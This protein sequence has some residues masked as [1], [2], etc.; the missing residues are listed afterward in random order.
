MNPQIVMA[1]VNRPAAAELKELLEASYNLP[2]ATCDLGRVRLGLPE[3]QHVVKTRT[4]AGAKIDAKAH[5]LLAGSGFNAEQVHSEIGMLRFSV[6]QDQSRP[7]GSATRGVEGYLSSKKTDNVFASIDSLVQSS[8]HDFDYFVAQKLALDWRGLKQQIQTMLGLASNAQGAP[9]SQSIQNSDTSAFPAASDMTL[10]AIN[11][12]RRRVGR[13]LLGE[14]STEIPDA[15]AVQRAHDFAAVVTEI[16][17]AWQLNKP[18]NV[19][20]RFCEVS[21]AY[22]LANCPQLNDT[23]KAIELLAGPQPNLRQFSKQYLSTRPTD[24]TRMRQLITFKS[25][26]Y[27]EQQYRAYIEGEIDSHRHEANL[28]GVPSSY[29]KVKAFVALKFF[30]NGQWDSRIETINKTPIWAQ[31]YYLV[32]AGY[33]KEASQL[34]LERND[35][36]ESVESTF[37]AYFTAYFQSPD[38]MLSEHYRE[39]IHLEYAQLFRPGAVFDPFKQALYKIIGRCELQRS[40]LPQVA[41]T[42]EDWMWLQLALVREAVSGTELRNDRYDLTDLQRVVLETGPEHFEPTGLNPGKYFGLQILIG[43]YENAVEFLYKSHELYAI[44]YAIALAAYGLLRPDDTPDMPANDSAVA[45]NADIKTFDFAGAVGRYTR[46]MRSSEP[47]SAVN[48]L[49][50]IALSA[51]HNPAQLTLCHEALQELVLE[52]RKFPE[53]IGDSQDGGPQGAIDARRELIGL[54]AKKKYLHVIAHGSAIKADGDGRVLDAILLYHLSECDEKVLEMVNH[55]LGQTLASAELGQPLSSTPGDPLISGFSSNSDPVQLARNLLRIQQQNLS[56][57]PDTTVTTSSRRQTT[58]TLL[59]IAEAIDLLAEKRYN[60]CL[61]R[62][63]ESGIVILS[64]SIAEVR[65]HALQFN[66]YDE[67]VARNIPNV[68][69]IAMECCV[70]LIQSLQTSNNPASA[71]IIAQHKRWAANCMIYAG[72]LQYRMPRQVY[73]RLTQ[74]ELNLSR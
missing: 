48:Y 18:F 23:W 47:E 5:Y 31:L 40:S 73:T 60:E 35:I 41:V 12:G 50:L 8:A 65:E 42:T 34:V 54:A 58:Q 64:A 66:R 67:S 28:G 6:E 27:L 1:L 74:L 30:R 61:E 45:T 19:A 26:E 33:L 25:K 46:I 10:A 21:A 62:L 72:L 53:L 4:P 69:V 24:Q 20:R 38:H 59:L 29:N 14:A 36:F 68:L 43:L 52:T 3:L 39:M 49:V 22:E 16:N 11:W 37:A 9:A 15:S 55:A 57:R 13:F 44:H 56:L 51:D 70:A 2:N 32:R 17:D 63:S 71:Y 7:T